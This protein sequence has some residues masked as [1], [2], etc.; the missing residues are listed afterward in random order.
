MFTTSALRFF[1][2]GQAK[3]PC[4]LKINLQPVANPATSCFLNGIS[5]ETRAIKGNRKIRLAEK[6]WGCFPFTSET[7]H[8]RS[9][10]SWFNRALIWSMSSPN[11]DSRSPAADCRERGFNTHTHTHTQ[12]PVLSLWGLSCSPLPEPQ[13]NSNPKFKTKS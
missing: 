10:M 2:K 5:C 6:Q 13:P 11:V 8:I 7:D 3:W 1:A 4:D 12:I 9:H